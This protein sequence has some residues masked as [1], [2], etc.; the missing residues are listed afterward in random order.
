MQAAA[1][2]LDPHWQAIFDLLP[3]HQFVDQL[4]W[5]E[6]QAALKSSARKNLIC[7][8]PNWGCI[9]ID[10]PEAATFLQGQL[11]N[12]AVNLASDET[13]LAAHCDPKGRMHANFYLHRRSEQ[14]FYL[15]MPR[16][17]VTTALRAL[18]KY[19][20]FSKAE[21][22]DISYNL[23]QFALINSDEK[24]LTQL[25][26]ADESAKVITLPTHHEQHLILVKSAQA[27]NFVNQLNATTFDSEMLCW[28][29]SSHWEYH[30]IQQGI[31]FIQPTT[32]GEMIPQML[33][34]DALGGISFT[35]GCYTGQEIIARMKYRG[36]VKRRC[37]PFSSRPVSS[38]SL[39]Q[40][41]P[42]GGEIFDQHGKSCGLNVSV[43]IDN[44]GQNS[45]AYGLAV[46][47]VSAIE[48]ASKLSLSLP[49]SDQRIDIQLSQLPYSL[50]DEE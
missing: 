13:I 46:L 27:L 35:K 10:G 20:V 1:L 37:Y 36:K 49:D 21:L 9:A 38:D 5:F 25:L 26:A 8:L 48:E 16:V 40:T 18:K 11:T 6:H 24:L 15:F 12:D 31:A 39:L 43:V 3:D 29:G 23:A 44:T 17:T 45:T 4:S 14:C 22:S 32:V 42:I 7:P 47:K 50:D 41:L 30:L 33:N 28:A 2:S 34:L 19:A